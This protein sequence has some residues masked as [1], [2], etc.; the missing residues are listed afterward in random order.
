M[1]PQPPPAKK[2]VDAGSAVT[3]LPLSKTRC[4]WNVQAGT[5]EPYS[6]SLLNVHESGTF[7]CVCCDLPL[8]SSKTKFDS[9]TGWPRLGR[10]NSLPFLIR[11]HDLLRRSIIGSGPSF[12]L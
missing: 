2:T 5:E 10:K 4:M 7:E 6:S 3:N 12:V 11:F 1:T 8:F 9:H